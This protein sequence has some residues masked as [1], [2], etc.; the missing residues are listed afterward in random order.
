MAPLKVGDTFPTAKFSYIP[1]TEETSDIVAC[2]TPAPYDAQ[3]VHI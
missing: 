1:Y 3:K 2:G